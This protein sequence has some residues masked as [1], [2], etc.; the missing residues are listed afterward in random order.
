MQQL[1]IN[2]Q[3][4]VRVEKVRYCGYDINAEDRN[5]LLRSGLDGDLCCLKL[6]TGEFIVS[7]LCNSFNP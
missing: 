5:T 1:G 4:E 2:E 3:G 7:L 6:N